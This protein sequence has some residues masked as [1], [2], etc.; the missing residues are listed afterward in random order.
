MIM[1]CSPIRTS[2]APLYREDDAPTLAKNLLPLYE[3]LLCSFHCNISPSAGNN[4]DALG[5]WLVNLLFQSY[6]VF[7]NGEGDDR[8]EEIDVLYFIY[9]EVHYA[10]MERKVLL[11]PPM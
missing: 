1:E 7:H 5:G 4:D 3:I 2:F 10:V 11:M 6:Q 8:S 9:E